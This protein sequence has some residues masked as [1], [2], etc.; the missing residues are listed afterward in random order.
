MVVL[1]VVL[2]CFVLMGVL[3]CYL[4]KFI[5]MVYREGVLCV[6]RVAWL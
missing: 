5:E 3:R 1:I 6:T 4:I 2:R